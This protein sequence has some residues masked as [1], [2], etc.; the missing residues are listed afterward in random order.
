MRIIVL[1]IALLFTAAFWL[2]TALD[3]VHN[4]F[5][6]LDVIAILILMLFTIALVGASRNPPPPPPH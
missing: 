3:I 5:S 1:A 2:L 4:G 6:P